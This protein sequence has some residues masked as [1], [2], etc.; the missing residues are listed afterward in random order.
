MANDAQSI[1]TPY[2]EG[3]RRK[4]DTSQFVNCRIAGCD[5]LVSSMPQ[6]VSYVSEN[7]RLL[8]GDYVMVSAT[9]EI[10]MACE[11]ERFYRCQNG[12]VVSIPD[13]APLVTFGRR[14]GHPEMQ[15]ITGPDFMLEMLKVSAEKGL[16][17][18]FYGNNE[19]TLA[20]MRERLEKDFPGL[21]IA[22]MKPSVYRDLTEEEDRALLKEINAT[23]PDFVWICLGAPRG[24]YFAAEHQGE[25]EGLLVSVGAAFDY[26][27]GSIQ[28][29]PKWMQDHDLEWLYRVIQEPK[30]LAK[31][32]FYTIPRFFWYAYIQKR[33][34]PRGKS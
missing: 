8:S 32:Y 2:R 34:A 21:Q 18:Y 20:K 5:I 17:H 28:R 27:V 15:R 7:I 25:M 19:E 9:N 6:L 31:R 14:H 13:G 10:V 33:T 26:F 11:S 24:C 30:R 23:H 12:G 1:M 29:A 22:G 16:R 4:A 3:F